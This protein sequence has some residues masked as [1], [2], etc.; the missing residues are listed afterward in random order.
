MGIIGY[1]I[2]ELEK[3]QDFYLV[4]GTDFHDL[5]IPDYMV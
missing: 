1:S 4:A 3:H 5:S 2:K